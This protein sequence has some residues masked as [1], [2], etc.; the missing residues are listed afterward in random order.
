VSI[1]VASVGH[2]RSIS[3]PCHRDAQPLH[4]ID[5]LS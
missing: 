1:L 3:L 2:L 5:E 4:G